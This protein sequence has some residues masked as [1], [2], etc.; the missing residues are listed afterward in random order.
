MT[1]VL[2]SS[3]FYILSFEYVPL[4]SQYSVSRVFSLDN[5]QSLC[6]SHLLLYS[7]FSFFISTCAATFLVSQD[8]FFIHQP[9]FFSFCFFCYLLCPCL[10][11]H[12]LEMV[13]EIIYVDKLHAQNLYY[14]SANVGG[15]KVKNVEWT[16][17]RVHSAMETCSVFLRP[18]WR[19][20]TVFLSCLSVFSLFPH[21]LHFPCA[22]LVFLVHT[23]SEELCVSSWVIIHRC[24]VI[25]PICLLMSDYKSEIFLAEP[26]LS[27]R[28]GGGKGRG[29]RPETVL[30]TDAFLG[31]VW[32]E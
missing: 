29:I 2:S 32:T 16:D 28:A 10:L 6:M 15:A 26:G 21:S 19:L 8:S 12:V 13:V 18:K 17:G 14:D 20:S 30:K 1:L 22:Q 23:K 9:L 4:F 31:W 11:H 27:H 5:F 24:L 3:S 25:L 7:S